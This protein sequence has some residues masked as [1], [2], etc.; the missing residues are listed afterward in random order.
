MENDVLSGAKLLRQVSFRGLSSDITKR[1]ASSNAFFTGIVC[2]E[3]Y[4]PAAQLLAVVKSL[5]NEGS[6]KEFIDL[7]TTTDTIRVPNLS[8]SVVEKVLSGFLNQIDALTSDKVVGQET[9]EEHMAR[10]VSAA[11]LTAPE[12]KNPI[13]IDFTVP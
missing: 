11:I 12:K 7:K 6:G 2:S 3:G 8:L 5:T 4:V 1:L 13:V 9:W 10:K